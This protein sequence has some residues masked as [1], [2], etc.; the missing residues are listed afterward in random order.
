MDR[1]LSIILYKLHTS[2]IGL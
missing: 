2:E 1:S